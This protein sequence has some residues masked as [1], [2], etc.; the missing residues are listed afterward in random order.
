VPYQALLSS[1]PALDQPSEKPRPDRLGTPRK[2]GIYA[3]QECCGVSRVSPRTCTSGPTVKRTSC[4]SCAGGGRERLSRPDTP[5]ASRIRSPAARTAATSGPAPQHVARHR[6]AASC[7]RKRPHPGR[8]GASG[9]PPWKPRPGTSTGPPSSLTS[10]TSVTRRADHDAHRTGAGAHR[11]VGRCGLVDDQLG[12]P[13]RP[14]ASA[15]CHARALRIG[16]GRQHEHPPDRV[17][18]RCPAAAA[19]SRNPDTARRLRRRRPA[20]SHP[21]QAAA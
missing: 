12:H 8:S 11:M 9:R 3:G 18:Q 19:G 5:T 20:A 13:G 6:G 10:G 21:V 2:P 14:P 17:S 1:A 4:R 7:P 15:R 16:R